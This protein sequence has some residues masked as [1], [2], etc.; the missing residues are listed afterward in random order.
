MKKTSARFEIDMSPLVGNVI[1]MYGGP[2]TGW[3]N[4]IVREGDD[5]IF[6]EYAGDSPGKEGSKNEYPILSEEF[7]IHSFPGSYFK[8]R[9]IED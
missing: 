4:Y 6:F 3:E 8:C 1:V 5:G 7:R 2:E 9:L